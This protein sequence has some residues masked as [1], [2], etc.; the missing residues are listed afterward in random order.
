MGIY[1]WTRAR[2]LDWTM[3][4]VNT[5]RPD[6]VGAASGHVLEIG[7]GSGLNLPLYPSAV[8]QLTALEPFPADGLPALERRIAQAPYP[9]ERVKLPAD[10]PLPFP[11]D[12]FDTVV[13]TWTLCSIPDPDAALTELKRVLRPEG[14]FLFIEHGEAEDT[15]S[16]RWQNRVNP[17]W[18]CCADGCN[19]NRPI[20]Q[21]IETAGFTVHQLH[22]FRQ[23]WLGLLSHM[24]QGTAIPSSEA[25]SK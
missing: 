20:G 22:R 14:Q 1:S 16:K 2:V 3:G 19:I 21:L 17:L 9:V 4:R 15:R 6:A 12:H 24:Y 18:R 5:L 8:T 10:G 23:P 25:C 11:T 13:S 7:F